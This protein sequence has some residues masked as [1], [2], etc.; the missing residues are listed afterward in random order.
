[1]PDLGQSLADFLDR[2]V[3]VRIDP[4]EDLRRVHL[5]AM[6]CAISTHRRRSYIALP[7]KVLMPA[8]RRSNRYLELGR[9]R[10]PRKS[11]FDGTDNPIP[12][13]I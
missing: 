11:A 10:P 9:C 7:P 5:D 8:H 4:A 12:K 13:I 2:D 1:M 6:A 3:F